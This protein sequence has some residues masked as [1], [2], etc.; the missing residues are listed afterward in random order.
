M[1]NTDLEKRIRPWNAKFDWVKLV[2]FSASKVRSLNRIHNDHWS[3][4]AREKKS[5]TTEMVVLFAD[6]RHLLARAIPGT[7]RHVEIMSIRKKLCDKMDN[8]AGGAKPWMD[9][10]RYAHVLE[11]DDPNHVEG[12][13]DQRK[14]RP[15]ELEGTEITVLFKAV[16]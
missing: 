2:I 14:V 7:V 4:R 6:Y 12:S 8:L 15:G 11:D 16:V 5:L 9:A 3:G 1:K 10:L 13:I